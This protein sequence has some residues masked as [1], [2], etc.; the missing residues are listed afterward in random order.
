M[1]KNIIC[2]VVVLT[3]VAGVIN[4]TGGTAQ[5]ADTAYKIGVTPAWAG[6]AA[7]HVA[8][9]KGFCEKRG[10]KIKVFGIETDRENL[11]AMKAGRLDMGIFMAGSLIDAYQEGV[12]V[13]AVAE[14]DWSHGGD[15][16]VVK[17]DVD[18]TQMKGKPIGVYLNQTCVTYFLD[19]Y[20]ATQDLKVSDFKILEIDDDSSLTDKFIS[21]MFS[22][23]VTYDP[24]AGRAVEKGNGKVIATT[25][26]Y[27][28]CMPSAIA[29]RKDRLE[30]IDKEDLKKIFLGYT[31]AAQ[32]LNDPA[33]WKEFQ[34]ILNT[35]TFKGD[36]GAPYSEADLKEMLDAV[37]I[38]DKA[39]LLERNK[40]GGGLETFLKDAGAFLKTSGNLKKEFTPSDI[41]DTSILLEAL[42]S[43]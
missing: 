23:I 4:L 36:E 42:Q 16:I 19:K 29:M 35:V 27:E 34:E 41:C 37:I 31:D 12:T 2:M 9:A 26:S 28:G 8:E 39:G 43:E 3:L 15:K 22:A 38:H 13:V 20:L 17:Q 14:T 30:S 18:L 25:A 40:P 5:A 11:E 21:G 33:N 32:W 24:E 6:W 7:F 10:A 1:M